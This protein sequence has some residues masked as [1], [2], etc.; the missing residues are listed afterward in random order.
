[1]KRLYPLL[2]ISV[3]IYWGCDDP[4]EENK[5]TPVTLSVDSTGELKWTM[6]EDT[7][8]FKYSL[9]GSNNSSME[10]KRLIYEPQSRLDTTYS[11]F[12]SNEY[13]PYYQ[14]DV[15]NLNEM[16]SS[17]NILINDWVNLWG[18]Y[19]SVLNTTV[20]NLSNSGLSGEIPSEIGNLTNLT[21][22]HLYNNQLIG[23]IPPEIGNLTNLTELWLGG[24]Q[25]TG[26]IPSEIGNLTNLFGLRLDRNQL[27]GII[28][29]EICNQGDS[30]P[31]L[32]NNQLCPPYPSCV[33][34]I[35]GEQ[36]TSDCD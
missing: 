22:L 6:N 33:E 30:S 7:D 18:E 10:N 23:S 31:N 14:V 27:S 26:S 24:N 25:L 32:S 8:F 12:D 15:M 5:P 17:S 13:F 3:L 4:K 29:D 16:V 28:P 35:V 34:D 20:L 19:Y 2:F 11:F 36:D 9:Y 1:M 21:E